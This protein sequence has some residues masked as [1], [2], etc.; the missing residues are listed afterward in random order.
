[1]DGGA[2]GPQLIQPAPPV[3]PAVLYQQ[4]RLQYQAQQVM[5]G[6][7]TLRQQ[8]E[9]LQ[10]HVPQVQ[11]QLTRV[12]GQVKR[13]RDAHGRFVSQQ[14]K[15]APKPKPEPEP[16]PAP[17]LESESSSS[18]DSSAPEA[19]PVDPEPPQPPPVQQHAPEG[20]V[21]GPFVADV[22]EE[23]PPPKL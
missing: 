16:E 15:A 10:A 12:S 7:K 8:T 13:L 18:S 11:A 21:A 22:G 2:F 17:P 14:A 6:Q 9:Q 4:M 3:P 20:A 19:D 1:M 5:S 23:A